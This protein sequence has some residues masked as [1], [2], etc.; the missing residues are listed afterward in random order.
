M[1]YAKLFA[2]I[3]T[4]YGEGDGS[5]TF[6]LP[7][8][9]DKTFWYST[10]HS[11]GHKEIGSLPAIEGDL[12]YE[13]GSTALPLPVSGAINRYVGAV[14]AYTRVFANYTST[15]K[16]YFDA[17]GS[18]SIYRSDD[19]QIVVPTALDVLFCIKYI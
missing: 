8:L 10:V 11:I 7:D 14:N 6:N 4:I 15:N 16:C 12:G 9:R 18:S 17:S 5:T 3:D 19:I 13:A 2:V 1:T